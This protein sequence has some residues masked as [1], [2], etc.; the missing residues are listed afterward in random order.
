MC[1]NYFAGRLTGNGNYHW[2]H[3]LVPDD[4][5]WSQEVEALADFVVGATETSSDKMQANTSAEVRR[6]C[7][8]AVAFDR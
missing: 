1:L 2:R 5:P 8:I 4:I 6:N 3:K 7:C